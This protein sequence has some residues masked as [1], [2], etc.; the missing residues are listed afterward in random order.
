LTTTAA[1]RTNCFTP[2]LLSR[3]VAKL[4]SPKHSLEGRFLVTAGYDDRLFATTRIGKR[5]E[6]FPCLPLWHTLFDNF[7]FCCCSQHQ[8]RRNSLP[9]TGLAQS[10]GNRNLERNLL[11]LQHAEAFRPHQLHQ[12]QDCR[13]RFNKPRHP[14]V[15]RV[16]ENAMRSRQIGSSPFYILQRPNNFQADEEACRWKSIT[17]RFTRRASFVPKTTHITHTRLKIGFRDSST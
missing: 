15:Y 3:K 10:T 8:M 1:A 6:Q 12:A 11:L 5:R 17:I 16:L 14:K 2:Y 13:R 7:S 4:A 9:Y